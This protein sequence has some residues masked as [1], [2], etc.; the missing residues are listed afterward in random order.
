[1][2]ERPI[3]ILSRFAGCTLPAACSAA[4]PAAA[5]PWV[6]ISGASCACDADYLVEK[7]TV[8]GVG[9]VARGRADVAPDLPGR[10]GNVAAD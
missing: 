2:V 4:G 8:P 10:N 5:N 6:L 3:G 7:A 9:A 1:M